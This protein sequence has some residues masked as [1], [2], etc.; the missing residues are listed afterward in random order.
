MPG[1]S[2]F[3][4]G[5][6]R[7][8]PNGH[9][10]I[11][12]T[13]PLAENLIG[14]W[15]FNEN[16]GSTVR[17]IAGRGVSK[18][19]ANGTMTSGASWALSTPFRNSC[20]Q[21]DL[22]GSY[23]DLTSTPTFLSKGVPF[24][25][26]WWEKVLSV[27][28]V[29]YP[30]RFQLQ[31]QNTDAGGFV[32]LRSNDTN[33]G[34]GVGYQ[35][36]SWGGAN[37]N[38]ATADFLAASAPTLANSVGIW[39]NWILIGATGP[40]S[41]TNGDY[42]VYVD[43]LPF[44]TT[45]SP[46]IGAI[47]NNTNRF[48]Q[49]SA[50]DTP[51]NCL[52]DAVYIYYNRAFTAN[53]VRMY[54][55]EPFGFFQDIPH[56]RDFAYLPPAVLLTASDAARR[57][58]RRKVTGNRPQKRRKVPGNPAPTIP[59]DSTPLKRTKRKTRPATAR[60]KRQRAIPNFPGLFPPTTRAELFRKRQRPRSARTGRFRFLPKKPTPP[61]PPTGGCPTITVIEAMTATA[62]VIDAMTATGLELERLTAKASPYEA[63]TATALAEEAASGTARVV[64]CV[65]G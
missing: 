42:T 44:T 3:L 31:V 52:L 20:I 41:Q 46:G 18:S 7:I 39:H 1:R 64:P 26:C 45:S 54:Y 48:G 55:T 51:S 27:S 19:F 28:G 23:I 32:V 2:R 65:K 43:G 38:F 5:F 47:P 24:T 33:S 62:K 21:Q 36:L 53:D 8:K 22:V 35:A 37:A 9:A 10:R 15:L 50:G 25:I 58:R 12:W 17:D 34:G 30:S 63:A 13:H 56:R 60:K 29:V 11:D 4:R 14:A 40:C 6:R 59:P 61:P 57:T 49:D 16:G